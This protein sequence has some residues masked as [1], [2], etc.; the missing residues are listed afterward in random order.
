[1]PYPN[2]MCASAFSRP[3]S[4][5]SGE[6][7]TVSSCAAE[8]VES[9]TSEPSGIVTPCSSMSVRAYRKEPRLE[10]SMRMH[11]S[12]AFSTCSGASGQA[13]SR[14]SLSTLLPS[15]L[16][17]VSL[18]PSRIVEI[19][20]TTSRWESSVPMSPVISEVKSSRGAAAREATSLST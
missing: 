11:S 19:S 3:R 7:K 16:G 12:T 2:V 4:N 1:M 20:S 9:R 5:V 14:S 8:S 15:W 13:S 10:P 17:T 6:G 18:P